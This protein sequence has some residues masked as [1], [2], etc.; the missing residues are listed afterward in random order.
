MTS[1]RWTRFLS[2]VRSLFFEL[3]ICFHL[4]SHQDFLFL[5]GGIC[6]APRTHPFSKGIFNAFHNLVNAAGL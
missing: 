4:A 1:G 5:R 2:Q 3:I 6:V